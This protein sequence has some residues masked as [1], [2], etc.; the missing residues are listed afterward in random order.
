MAKQEGS[1]VQSSSFVMFKVTV[2]EFFVD[3]PY[4]DSQPIKSRSAPDVLQLI[5]TGSPNFTTTS[6]GVIVRSQAVIQEREKSI[7]LHH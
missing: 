6:E 4:G 7:L 5:T 3:P 1:K 2:E